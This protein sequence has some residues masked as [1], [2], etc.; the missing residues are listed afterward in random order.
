MDNNNG[1]SAGDILALTKNN[2]TMSGNF[3]YI[4][5]FFIIAGM[6]NGGGLFGNNGNGANFIS[7]EFIK[8]DIFNTNENVSTTAC[9]TQRDVLD[10]RY[11][12]GTNILENRYAD[13]LNA[14]DINASVKDCCCTTN[15]NIDSVRYDT[16]LGQAQ[17]DKD[18]ILGNQNIQKDML[19]GNQNLQAKLSEC[20]L[21]RLRKIVG[22]LKS[23][24]K[25]C[26]A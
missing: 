22:N 16:A 21:T 12:L 18:I 14:R 1:L 17:L 8:R 15:R 9:T 3:W 26:L 7:D 25:L 2:D 24:L 6:F 10:N 4:I 20:C 23:N 5:I 13:S 11:Q 19:L